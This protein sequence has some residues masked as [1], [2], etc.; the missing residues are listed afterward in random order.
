M[1]FILPFLLIACL[2]FQSFSKQFVVLQFQRNQSEIAKTL[3]VKKE[4]EGNT[5]QGKCHL[6]KQLEKLDTNEKKEGAGKKITCDFSYISPKSIQC[7]LG[8]KIV[9]TKNFFRYLD[10]KTVAASGIDLQPPEV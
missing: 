9:R 5:C 1:R 7:F 8:V 3:C 4:V 6:K 2:L 10:A